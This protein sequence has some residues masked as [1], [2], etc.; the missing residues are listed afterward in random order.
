M[1]FLKTL[2]TKFLGLK[3]WQKV[4][5]IVLA[6]VVGSMVAGGFSGSGQSGESSDKPTPVVTQ[7]AQPETTL[8][9]I[10][11]SNVK[12]EN[13]APAVKQRIAD[14]IDAGDCQN[15]QTEFDVA[16][17]NNVAQRNRTGENNA[18]LMSLLDDQM[19]KIGCY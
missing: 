15:L 18:S 7:E 9:V 11:K 6:Y 1:G 10:S 2:W 8:D 19:Q 17:Q 4:L 13:Y 5:V 3:T 14:L 12:W 16:D